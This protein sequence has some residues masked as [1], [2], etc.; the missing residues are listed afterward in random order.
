M[1]KVANNGCKIFD[2]MG[3]RFEA[4]LREHQI[5]K[6]TTKTSEGDVTLAN[7]IAVLDVRFDFDVLDRLHKPSFIGIERRLSASADSMGKSGAGEQ[8]IY[9]IYEIVASNPIHYQMLGVNTTIPTVI[10]RE[11]LNIIE[12]SWGNSDDTWIDVI[13]VPTNYMMEITTKKG[14]GRE[15]GS[16]QEQTLEPVFARS[17]FVP[18]IGSKAHLLSNSTVEKFLCV[19]GGA[20]LGMMIGFDMPL[21][22]NIDN[23]IRYHTGIF[24]FTGS[25]KSN[26]IS[27]LIREA[28]KISDLY[29]VIF[30]VAGEYLIHLLDIISHDGGGGMIYTT[31]DFNDDP[32]KFFNSQV[33]PETLEEK[34]SESILI[35]YIEGIIERGRVK[36]ISLS[37]ADIPTI[38]L[39]YL[40]SMLIKVSES[41]KAGALQARIVLQKIKGYLMKYNGYVDITAMEKGDREGLKSIV[42]NFINKLNERSSLKQD[43]QTFVDYIDDIEERDA[44][45][46]ERVGSG[47][48]E[49][50]LEGNGK[51][52]STAPIDPERLAQIILSSN[53][54]NLNIL[55]IPEPDDARNIA[56]RFINRLFHLKK[57][58]GSKRKVLLV[59]DEAQE[60]IP[61][62]TNKD[63][64]SS[65]SNRAVEAL[66]RQ[67]RKYRLHCW[68]STQ[69]V[70]H[71]NV[72][73]LQQLHSYFVS[74]LPRSYDKMVI[75]DAFSLSY[76]I[77]ERTTELETGQWLFVSYKATKQKNVPVFIQ[78]YNNEDILLKRLSMKHIGSGGVLS[79][80]R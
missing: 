54:P 26:L 19:E 24:G 1:A 52:E 47:G 59:I 60:F 22:V 76:S 9:L 49:D 37:R 74:V 62:R 72:N 2:D 44:D 79:P 17:R 11:Y 57:V 77:L 43:L 53:A 75:A 3:G 78:A 64:Y 34:L 5:V 71:L 33:I 6:R 42:S 63:D 67:G 61:D 35:R 40:T 25:G 55:Y 73:A 38:T 16:E 36:R 39:N 4:R 31:E 23:M 58:Y 66:L 65:L 7:P 45:S 68:L 20:P 14:D 56:S 29:V 30:D 13:A 70:A 41:D 28:L 32:V 48:V 10:R 12:A 27:Y 69:R 21:T 80:H 46:I 8:I 51:G 18:L 15:A 50:R